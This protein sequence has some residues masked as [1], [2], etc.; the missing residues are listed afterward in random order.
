MVRVERVITHMG[1]GG[2]LSESVG[3][4]GHARSCAQA[5]CP[6]FGKNTEVPLV[7]TKSGCV[8]QSGRR[9]CRLGGCCKIGIGLRCLSWSR[10][11]DWVGFESGLGPGW[12]YSRGQ[13]HVGRKVGTGPESAVVGRLGVPVTAPIGWF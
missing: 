13:D 5:S 10:D 11:Q 4:R 8:N 9:R 2:V 1:A 3:S 12:L 7:C 6:S